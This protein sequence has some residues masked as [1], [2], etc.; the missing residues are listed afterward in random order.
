MKPL[1]S[2]ALLLGACAAPA[3]PESSRATLLFF[4]TADCP[5]ANSF[6]PEIKRIAA[7]Y[8]SRV[9]SSLVYTDR[10]RTLED[11]RRHALDYGYEIAVRL[12][13]GRVLSR[14]Y[15]VTVTPEA[16]LLGG[17]GSRVYRGRIDDRYL[18]PGRYRLQPTTHELRDAIDAVLAGRPV[19][20]AETKAAGCPLT[21]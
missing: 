9:E 12:D 14:R 20:V 13:E 21:E 2:L 19:P 17:D 10:G 6:A 1:A 16:V 8:G 5:I 4:I 3:D 11:A 18:A 15:G 7:E